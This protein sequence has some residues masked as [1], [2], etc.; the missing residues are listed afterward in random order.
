MSTICQKTLCQYV[1]MCACQYVSMSMCQNAT[2][3][4]RYQ[5]ES[6]S[7]CHQDVIFEG[8]VWPHATIN[9]PLI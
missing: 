9:I 3:E 6:C 2:F 8:N 7:E 4:L 5:N 1:N